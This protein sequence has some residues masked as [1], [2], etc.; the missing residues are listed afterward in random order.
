MALPIHL[1]INP[2]R[3][4]DRH[5]GLSGT[6]RKVC[7]TVRRSN[8]EE[9]KMPSG[10][11]RIFFSSIARAALLAGI[12]LLSLSVE[13]SA[14][15][16]RSNVVCREELSRVHREQLAAKLRTIT[17]LAQLK[18]ADDGT[19]REGK[20]L[21]IGGS[22]SARELIAR[23]IH[24]HNVMVLEDASNRSDVAFCRVIPGKWK[25]RA[26]DSPPVFVVQI[27]FVDFERLVGDERALEAF[28]VGWG[29]LHELDHAVNDSVDAMTLGATGECE[30][31]LNQMR[32][33][34]DLP[35]RADYFSTLLPLAAD[36]TFATRF[37][38]LA[39]EQQ[40]PA[41]NKKKR[42]WVVWDANVVGGQLQ[43]QIAVLR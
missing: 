4:W 40:L 42:Y 30:A 1:I 24:G 9:A 5:S 19:L 16:G 3:Q 7:P 41:A 11:S 12:V 14:A 37:V 27:D 17:G 2:T 35:E 34:C 32:R 18:F 22:A 21:P 29:F 13:I 15:P 33:E 28:N 38:R 43:N 6:D 39:F 10:P 36:S 26:P 25:T 31:H 20:E 23:A 8:L